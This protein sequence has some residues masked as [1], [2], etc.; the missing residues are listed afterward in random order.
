MNAKQQ[1]NSALC[2][3]CRHI[4][5]L[6][7]KLAVS[8][9]KRTISMK[10]LEGILAITCEDPLLTKI[11]TSSHNAVQTYDESE[12]SNSRQEKAGIVFPPSI[13]EKFLRNF[14]Y[15]DIHISDITPVYFAAFIQT[16]CEEIVSKSG[17]ITIQDGRK[18]ITIRDLELTIRRSKSLNTFFRNCKLYFVGGGIIPYIHES[19]MIRP[20]RPRTQKEPKKRRFRP[21]TVSLREIKK[22]QQSSN[23]LFFQKLPFER[24]VRKI[25]S[26][27]CCLIPKI[28][29]K[30]FILMQYYIEQF[31]TDILF[32]AN[33]VAIHGNHVKIAASDI[34]FICRLRRYPCPNKDNFMVKTE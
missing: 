25:I 32:D 30:V 27:K 31:L 26:Q 3:I 29:V 16:I 12:N 7:E 11:I 6:V 13:V 15:R 22:Y 28:S 9:E 4:A 21:G 23:C 33:M 2:H 24:L 10:E 17:L 14:G 19:L 5:N 18:R 1:L 20:K 8:T 34:E